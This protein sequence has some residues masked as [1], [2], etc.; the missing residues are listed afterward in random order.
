MFQF[1]EAEVEQVEQRHFSPVA[2]FIKVRC[3]TSRLWHCPPPP[4]R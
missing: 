3:K 4:F 1:L 2:H